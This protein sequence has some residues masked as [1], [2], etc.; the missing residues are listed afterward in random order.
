MSTPVQDLSVDE[1]LR[2]IEH[3]GVGRVGWQTPLGPRIVPVGFRVHTNAIVFRTSPHSE[4]GR[5]GRDAD[6]AFEVDALDEEISHGWSVVA[7]GRLT[8]VDAPPEVAAIQLAGDPH[9]WVDGERR[10]YLK[11]VWRQLTGRRIGPPDAGRRR[12]AGRRQLVIRRPPQRTG[13]PPRY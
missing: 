3:S 5:Y 6:V 7:T 12:V 10:L 8:V 11:L 2:L 9:P 4:L 13:L 1:C